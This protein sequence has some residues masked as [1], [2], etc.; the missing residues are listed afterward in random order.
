MV[1]LCHIKPIHNKGVDNSTQE[2]LAEDFTE[3]ERKIPRFLVQATTLA[4]TRCPVECGC[5]A[6]FTWGIA[7]S[8]P[9][10]VAAVG[11]NEAAAQRAN[12]RRV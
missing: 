6:L 3:E 11:S 5:W 10:D 9:C 4:P 1:T 12:F 2:Q 8:S 7:I